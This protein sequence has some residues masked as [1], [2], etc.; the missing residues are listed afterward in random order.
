MRILVLGRGAPTKENNMLGSFEYEQ[1]QMLARNGHEVYYPSIDLRSIRHWRRWGLFAE[2]ADGVNSIKLNIPI[3][4]A[5]PACMRARLQS[6]LFR[7]QLK[8]I[9]HRY[10]IPDIVHVHYPAAFRYDDFA[11]LQ[12][13]GAKVVGTE[14]W[15]QVQNKTLPAQNLKNLND[16]VSN[17]DKICCVGTSLKKSIIELTGTKKEIVIVPNV[18]SKIFKPVS[19]NHQGFCFISSGR[20]VPVKQFD[21]IVEAFLNVFQ[22]NPEVSLTLAG[23]GEE[24]DKIVKILK[25]RKAENQVHLLGTVSRQKMADLF[26]RSDALVVFS[27]LETF[28]VPVIEAW[29]CGK[30]VIATETTV[31]ADNSDN[32]LGIMVDCENRQSLEAALRSIYARYSDYN[33]NWIMDYAKKHFSEDAVYN[34]IFQLYTEL[35]NE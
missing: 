3:G 8:K 29:A 12:E 24:H 34:Q 13:Q 14:H 15:T 2:N 19:E 18:V 30:P 5:L 7:W 21:T 20:L 1:A 6:F 32:R 22:G 28:C 31:L 33:A 25:D 27:R 23:N 10:G 17:A 16:F 4:R 26:A 35:I 9:A 11:F